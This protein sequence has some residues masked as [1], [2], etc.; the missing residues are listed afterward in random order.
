[1]L[2]RFTPQRLANWIFPSLAQ[3]RLRLRVHIQVGGV[4]LEHVEYPQVEMQGVGQELRTHEAEIVR[5]R[6]V[7]GVLA[8]GCPGQRTDGEVESGGAVLSL[9]VP[10][11]GEVHHPV[12]LA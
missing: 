5:R 2:T 7:L 12:R 10:V 9:V 8:V 3:L 6:V 4:V 1:M 11:G